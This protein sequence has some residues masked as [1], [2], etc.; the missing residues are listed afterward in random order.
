MED[1]IKAEFLSYPSPRKCERKV[2]R[3]A[4]IMANHIKLTA[5][6]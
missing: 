2:S 5:S 1:K 3:F 6:L 4:K